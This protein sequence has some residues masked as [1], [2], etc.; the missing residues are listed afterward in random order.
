MG[1]TG[2]PDPPNITEPQTVPCL[3]CSGFHIET[4]EAF[5]RIVGYA[6]LGMVENERSE[7]R[8]IARVVMPISTARALLTD[9]RKKLAKGGH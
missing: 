8:I 9:I 7:R 6:D 5:I 2:E 3:F 4:D 1:M